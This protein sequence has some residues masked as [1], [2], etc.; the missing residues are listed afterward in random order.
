MSIIFTNPIPR[1]AL[2]GGT[3][4]REYF[5]FP[6]DFG[7]DAG[8]AWA[9]S[10]QDGCA[11]WLTGG[12]YD[13]WSLRELWEQRPGLFLSRYQTFPFIISLVAPLQDLSIQVHPDA[14]AAGKLGYSS[15]KNEAWVFLKAPDA[16][17]IL[18]GHCARD[19][20][21]LRRH[22]SQ[23]DWAH[24]VRQLPVAAGDTVYIPAGVV[25]ALRKDS[26]V[27]EIQQ[28]TDITYRFYDYG[29][30]DGKG[31]PRPLQLEEAI[32][33][34]RY[35]DVLPEARPRQTVRQLPGVT[36]TTCVAN[37]SFVVRRIDCHGECC[38]QYPGYQLMTVVA[39]ESWAADAVVSMGSSFLLPAGEALFLRGE[40]TLM[41]TAE[42]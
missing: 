18:Y 35:G 41:A 2:W 42:Q 40:L 7:D 22:I 1:K 12:G 5:H 23:G 17:S 36:E 4:L 11:N 13:G 34:L 21:A 8:Q 26:V 29:R 33:C 6:A 24:L 9:F 30:L 16:A 20:Q 3:A 19:E 31:Q 38:L 39:G 37:D 32:G 25:H 28:A 14:A 15:G 10:A 27:Y